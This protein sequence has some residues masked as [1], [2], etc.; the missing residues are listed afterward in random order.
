MTVM[1][2]SLESAR[3]MK[4]MGFRYALPHM[5]WEHFGGVQRGEWVLRWL[6]YG[7]E[8]A[9]EEVLAAPHPVEALE[10]LEAEKGVRFGRNIDAP[11]VWLAFLSGK[12]TLEAKT[13]A[14]L[15]DAV[16]AALK[17]EEEA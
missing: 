11:R 4:A 3:A 15:L 12:V 7:D 6:E 9:G 16:Q 5:V 17:V 14:D 13:A 8:V 1:Q 10:W 2:V